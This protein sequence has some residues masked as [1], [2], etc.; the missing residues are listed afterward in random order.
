MFWEVRGKWTTWLVELYCTAQK[1]A[2]DLR[3]SL[4]C[5]KRKALQIDV[6]CSIK[7]PS[8]YSIRKQ[9]GV[10]SFCI[11]CLGNYLY[12]VGVSLC[13]FYVPYGLLMFFS[14]FQIFR[15]MAHTDFLKSFG[16]TCKYVGASIIYLFLEKTE[17]SATWGQSKKKDLASFYVH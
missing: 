17:L 8:H 1:L 11:L 14:P 10:Y 9:M 12:V 5:G 3:K 7:S 13:L 15:I 4:Y 2:D 16:S 6:F